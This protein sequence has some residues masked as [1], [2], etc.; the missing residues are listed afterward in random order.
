ME[1]V[2]QNVAYK[3]QT[4]ASKFLESNFYRASRIIFTRYI[5]LEIELE[6]EL[7]E[8]FHFPRC[9]LGNTAVRIFSGFL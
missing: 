1:E 6:L 9:D 2:E 4:S 3:Q 7:L 5:E 8:L